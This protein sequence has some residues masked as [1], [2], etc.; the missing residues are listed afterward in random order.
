MKPTAGDIRCIVFGHL[1][2]IAIW[3]LHKKWK[4][5]L[6]TP[7]RLERFNAAVAVY[8]E[9]APLIDTLA[10][11]APPGGLSADAGPLFTKALANAISI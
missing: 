5:A 8:G 4:A 6:P 2:R 3:H 10:K 9:P 1:T 7:E 11:E